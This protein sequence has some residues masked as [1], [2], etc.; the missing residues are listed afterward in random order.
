MKSEPQ[1]GRS[2]YQGNVMAMLA[3]AR[4]ARLNADAAHRD[5]WPAPA[6]IIETAEAADDSPVCYLGHGKYLGHRKRGRRPWP[7]APVKLLGAVT[8][9]AVTAVVIVVAVI[10]GTVVLASPHGQPHVSPSGSV[11]ASPSSIAPTPVHVSAGPPVF[12][13]LRLAPN[14]HGHLTYAVDNGVVYLLGVA[15]PD[16]RGSQSG[17][18]GPVATLPAL[19]RPADRLE[20]AAIISAAAGAITVGADGQIDIA[21][22]SHT[23]VTWVSLAGVAFPVGSSG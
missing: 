21:V 12:H 11:T 5:G 7:L 8:S 2:A 13:R 10:V 3:R 23:Y 20:L 18:Y 9:A 15:T 4:P 19:A 22:K 1:R 16:S 14:W 6:Q 17:N